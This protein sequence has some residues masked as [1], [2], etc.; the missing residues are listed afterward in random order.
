[1]LSIYFLGDMFCGIISPPSFQ[2]SHDQCHVEIQTCLFR[3]QSVIF[4]TFKVD[5]QASATTYKSRQWTGGMKITKDSPCAERA[6]VFCVSGTGQTPSPDA[7]PL[8][9]EN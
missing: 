6:W 3:S 1:M 7:G 5:H 2:S 8:L 9:D 4:L